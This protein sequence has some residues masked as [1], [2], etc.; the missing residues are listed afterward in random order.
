MKSSFILFSSID[1]H[2]AYNAKN[3]VKEDYVHYVYIDRLP[4]I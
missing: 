1:I 4:T 2:I 3:G